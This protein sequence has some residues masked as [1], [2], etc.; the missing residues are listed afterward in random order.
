VYEILP[1][2]GKIS[3]TYYADFREWDQ[4]LCW[5]SVTQRLRGAGRK[6]D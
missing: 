2:N 1:K 5:L 4:T 3:Y 6:R